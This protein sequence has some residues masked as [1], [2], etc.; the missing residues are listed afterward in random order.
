MLEHTNLAQTKS[1]SVRRSPTV[2]EQ[3]YL[4]SENAN[5]NQD[6]NYDIEHSNNDDTC[7]IGATNS[8]ITEI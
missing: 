6:I 4:N 7:K 2:V 8:P 5:I 1:Y 3:D